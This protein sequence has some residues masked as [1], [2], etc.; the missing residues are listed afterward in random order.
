MEPDLK[1]KSVGHEETFAK[2]LH[3]VDALDPELVR[4]ADSVGA[5]LRRSGLQGR[6]VQLK[7]R[8]RDFATIT[9][10]ET[11]ATAVDEGALIARVARR[12]L[13]EVDTSPG[14]RLLGVS[15]SQLE[16]ASRRQLSLDDAV[17]GS[18]DEVAGAVERIRER[19]GDSS[20][21]PATMTGRGTKRRGEQQWGPD[22]PGEGA[23]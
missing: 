1:P 5:R 7:V 6:T 9:R 22:H 23:P 10:S 3:T 16:D 14:V 4:M 18:W 15:V 19:F 20:I 21:V 12:L 17:G 8:F 2:D 11:V 13:H